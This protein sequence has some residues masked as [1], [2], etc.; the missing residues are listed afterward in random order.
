MQTIISLGRGWIAALVIVAASAA[1]C[2][3]DSLQDPPTVDDNN[4]GDDVGAGFV[5]PQPTDTDGGDVTLPDPEVTVAALIAS[6]GDGAPRSSAPLMRAPYLQQITAT[7]AVIGWGSTTDTE[8]HVDITTPDGAVV[9]SATSAIEASAL[10]ATGMRLRWATIQGLAPDTVYC[11]SLA[12][13]YDAF[14]ARAGFRTAPASDRDRTLRFVALGDSGTG[15]ADQRAVFEQMRKLPQ[16]MILHLGD[17]AYYDSTPDDFQARFFGVYA[18]LLQFVPVFPVAGNHEYVTADAEPFRDA[19]SLPNNERWFSFDWGNIHFAAIDTEQNLATQAAWLDADLAATNQP[20]KI[21]FC[22]RPPYSSGSHGS[23][24]DVR[25]AL[26]PVVERHGVQLVL[27]GH[28]HDYE[29]TTPQNGVTYIV[30]GGA[31]GGLRAVGTSAFTAY[32][33]S[34]LN[35]V[36]VEVTGDTLTLH[37]ID[38]AGDEFDT[39]DIPRAPSM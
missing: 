34:K 15:N 35:F 11:Y 17:M 38:G 32:S 28:E 1:G 16:E 12:T 23:A 2:A 21:V 26:A 8:Q 30:S 27:S 18:P 6:C 22:H 5:A 37:A 20:W 14:T 36:Q 19:F 29:R 25:N 7:S 10:T 13:G 4:P 9:M 31:G 3:T 39:I 24:L 33:V